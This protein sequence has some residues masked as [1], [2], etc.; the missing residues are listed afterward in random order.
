MASWQGSSNLSA[1]MEKCPPPVSL[2]DLSAAGIRLRASE[3]VTIVRELVLQVTRGEVAGVPSAHVIRLSAAGTV[4]VEGPVGAGGP[5]V[6]RA[7]Q[8]LESLLPAVDG[9]EHT[10]VPGGVRLV[11]AR[12]LGAIDLPP[13]T[14]LEAFAEALNRFASTDPA[15]TIANLATAWADQARVAPDDPEA[16]ELTRAAL[17]QIQPFVT[18]RETDPLGELT[19]SDI[20][21]ARR[22]TRMPLCE[23]S[24]RSRIPIGLL[25]QLEWGYLHN[26]PFGRY[27]R[28]QLVRYARATGLD[29]QV[30]VSTFM[31]LLNELE[32]RQQALAP[33]PP[34]AAIPA[35]VDSSVVDVEVIPVFERQGDFRIARGSQWRSALA[36]LAIPALLAIALLPAWWAR[37]TSRP[38]DQ[39]QTI[40]AARPIEQS[41]K[42]AV[43][44]APPG[45]LPSD[46]DRPEPSAPSMAPSGPS[47]G[48]SQAIA[49]IGR[50]SDLRTKPSEEGAGPRT[51]TEP[52]RLLEASFAAVGTAMF[53]RPGDDSGV[54]RA[55]GG[56]GDTMLRITKIVDDTANSFHLRVSPDGERIAFDSDRD[57][58]RG[59]YVADSNGSEV[60][61]VSGEGFAAVPS[62][63]PDG[64]RLAFVRAE[65]SRPNVWNVWTLDLAG[66]GAMHQ[67]TSHESGQPWGASWFPEGNRLAYSH[68]DRLIVRDLIAGTERVYP[69]PRRGRVLRT[70][71]VSPDGRRMIFHVERDGAWLLELADGSMRRVL[72]DPTAE[73]YAW[74]PDGSR[75]AYHSRRSSTWGVWIMAPRP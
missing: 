49:A 73:E 39:A 54:V 70:P 66:G 43:V 32:Q 11:V 14:S 50:R 63:S 44:A 74:S 29:E 6:A 37:S 2:A 31:P 42:S 48:E 61:R 67:I 46:A 71:I 59:V 51:G 22:A 57:G 38:S 17:A 8:L 75:F 53:S 21:R 60:R 69:S 15:E 62:W 72:E 16:S 9:N 24:D 36:A 55:G 1:G 68:A 30:V 58:I 5:S 65:P 20:R 64:K 27:G 34:V 28:T 52:D 25:R 7:A 23:V 56:A 47:P 45:S 3:V 26:W 13:F 12:A 35:P 4:S 18:P 41:S 40:D 33:R 10:R 19:V